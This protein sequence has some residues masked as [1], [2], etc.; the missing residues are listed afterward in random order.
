MVKKSIRYF[1]LLL[2][3]WSVTVGKI[4]SVSAAPAAINTL[5]VAYIYNIA[6][7]TRWPEN[8]WA[9]TDAPFKLCFYAKNGFQDGLKTLEKKEVNGHPIILLKPEQEA[10]FQQ[11]NAFYI[12][13]E[14]RRRYRYLLSLIDPKTVLTISDD[15]PFFDYGGLVNL[16]EKDQRLRFEVNMQQLAHSQLKFSSKLLKLA[17]LVDNTR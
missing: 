12:D 15:T 8:T 7:F 1:C 4:R 16:V 10:D 5:K 6:K 11:C 14:D 3:C 9:S 17:I 13:T 2:F